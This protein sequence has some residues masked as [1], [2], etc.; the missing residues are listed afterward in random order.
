LANKSITLEGF[1]GFQTYIIDSGQADENGSFSLQYD[2][3]DFG[4]GYLKLEDDKPF[5]LIL[6][7][8]VFAPAQ[9]ATWMPGLIGYWCRGMGDYTEHIPA[10]ITYSTLTEERPIPLHH[11]FLP[12]CS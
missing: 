11:Q 3:K 1:N 5:I 12:G 7:G 8:E 6:G 10:H 2:D 4:M 9:H